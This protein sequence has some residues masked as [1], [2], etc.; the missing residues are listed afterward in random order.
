MKRTLIAVAIVA[1]VASVAAFLY[2][3]GRRYE[4]VI[5]Q[6]QIDGALAD[7]FPVSKRY[8]LL[9]Q[10]TYSEPV[11]SLLPEANRIR[12]GMKAELGYKRDEQDEFIGGSVAVVTGIRYDPEKYQ[13]YL[14][15]P[16]I[17]TVS[18]QGVSPQFADR[19]KDGLQ[20]VSKEHLESIPV[21][22]IR[23]DDVKKT[24]ARMILK[25]VRIRDGVIHV[26][27]GL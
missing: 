1:L 20:A 12:V 26:T 27:L 24:V 23:A 21:Y 5:T 13:F 18:V 11:L 9:L 17:E 6:E 4:I 22:T 3:K 14:D 10:V 7:R 16:K 15:D 19:V 8:L 25:D 2:F